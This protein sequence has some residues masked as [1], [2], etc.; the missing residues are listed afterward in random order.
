MELGCPPLFAAPWSDLIWI[1]TRAFAIRLDLHARVGV[2][3][4]LAVFPWLL[5][6]SPRDETRRIAVNIAKLPE[7]PELLKNK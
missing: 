7:L 4:V 6:S 2:S 3:F 1:N 5:K